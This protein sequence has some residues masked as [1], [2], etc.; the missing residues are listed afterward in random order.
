MEKLRTGKMRTCTSYFKRCVVVHVSS[1]PL[2]VTLVASAD[3]NVGMLLQASLK[4]QAA[5][6]PVRKEAESETWAG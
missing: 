6:E 4:L 3:A 1:F 5:L 2:V